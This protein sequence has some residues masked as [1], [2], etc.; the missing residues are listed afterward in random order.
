MSD[1]ESVSSS[2]DNEDINNSTPSLYEES[3]SD[4][5]DYEFTEKSGL[6]TVVLW[7]TY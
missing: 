7:P 6:L 2:D 5:L 1:D 4:K 3:L